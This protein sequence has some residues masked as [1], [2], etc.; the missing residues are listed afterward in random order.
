MSLLS[1][2]TQVQLPHKN[3]KQLI[4]NLSRAG[5]VLDCIR[6]TPQ[7]YDL[8]RAYL[9]IKPLDFPYLASLLQNATQRR[10]LVGVQAS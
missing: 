4:K 2:F 5:E 9:G 1:V 10:L 6:A 7:W 8:T 3:I